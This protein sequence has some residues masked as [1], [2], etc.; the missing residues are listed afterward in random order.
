[1]CIFAV[2]RSAVNG[3]KTSKP[4]S[5]WKMFCLLII[6]AHPKNPVNCCSVC[7]NCQCE[8]PIWM[9]CVF[10]YSPECV[11][12]V[13]LAPWSSFQSDFVRAI[14]YIINRIIWPLLGWVEE[15]QSRVWCRV[16]VNGLF[17][18]N[19]KPYLES[20]QELLNSTTTAVLFSC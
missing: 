18:E 16:Q 1:M 11:Q 19:K 15:S 2:L 7:V 8:F 17:L 9:C 14:N 10:F 5:F 20:Y 4:P 12:F 6:T 3:T 13:S